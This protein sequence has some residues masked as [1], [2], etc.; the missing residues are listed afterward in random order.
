M[1]A[2]KRASGRSGLSGSEQPAGSASLLL[3]EWITL[4]PSGKQTRVWLRGAV[5]V[6]ESG[7]AGGGPCPQV[8]P[9]RDTLR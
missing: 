6:G 7:G 1:L 5:P 3:G 9:A 4:E 2:Q 8:G